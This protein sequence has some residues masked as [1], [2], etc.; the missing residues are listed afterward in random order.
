LRVYNAL[1]SQPSRVLARLGV[2]SGAR[3]CELISFVPEDFDFATL[4]A[5]TETAG[6]P[7]LT[8][9][10]IDAFGF[11][12]EL[13]NGYRYKHATLGAYVTA[14]CRCPACTQWSRDYARE[15]KRSRTGRVTREW[16]QARRNDPTGYLGTDVWR[17]IWVK[18]VADAE[19]PFKYTPYQ[20]RH[21]HASWLI[22]Q[23]ADLARVQYRPGH[24]DLQATT[25]YVKILDAEDTK[26]ADVMATILGDVALD[27]VGRPSGRA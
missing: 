4:F 1:A 15:R 14:K 18:A 2:S 16:S 27:W 5:S 9:E 11:T 10:E 13:P 7:R 25:R 19:L 12:D 26:A 17:R 3:L 22:D 8:P 21:T 6:K 24:G 20:V 23:G